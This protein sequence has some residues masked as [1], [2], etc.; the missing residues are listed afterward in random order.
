[1]RERILILCFL[2]FSVSVIAQSN[3]DPKVIVLLPKSVEIEKGLEKKIKFYEKYGVAFQK[4]YLLEKRD[5][6]LSVI[7]ENDS[8]PPNYKEHFKN[9]IDF[10]SEL[11][12]V[13]NIVWN[14]TESFHTMLDLDFE[15]SLVVVEKQKSFRD[16]DLM[17]EYAKANSADYLINID[18]LIVSKYKRDIL[19]KPVF[20]VY[21]QNENR[22]ISID[23]LDYDQFNR[24]YIKV[25]KK[26]LNIYFD[27]IDARTKILRI[28]KDN[29]N[30]QKRDLTSRKTEI[31]D[32][33]Y[34][35]GQENN[36]LKQI[37][38]KSDIKSE[39]YSTGIMNSDSSK[40]IV[41]F[42]TEGK[43]PIGE[44]SEL[45]HKVSILYG[46]KDNSNEWSFEYLQSGMY[47]KKELS[48]EQEI[49]SRFMK[50]E[51]IFFFEEEKDLLNEKFWT[52]ELFVKYRVRF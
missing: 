48:R 47:I 2:L 13:N 38:Q 6:L 29:G 23:P 1:M 22:L 30:S 52:E 36:W 5:S 44:N 16:F 49:K 9:Q 50:L 33:L 11:N 34:I 20:T 26:K 8:I 14:Y 35:A 37:I 18:S 4:N 19:I 27:D 7:M 10:A 21:Y 40:I 15:S 32:S 41:F 43:M 24:S 45:R 3:F 17:H 31:L 39:F 51:N 25:D 46:K 12:F 42:I 28:I